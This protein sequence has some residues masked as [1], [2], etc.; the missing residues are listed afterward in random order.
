MWQRL[1]QA[2][3]VWSSL[4][5]LAALALLVG[6]G[7][8]Q[9]ERLAWKE[10]LLARLAARVAAEPISLAAVERRWQADGDVEYLHALVRGRFHHDQERYLYAPQPA[11]LGW[12]VYTPLEVSPGRVLWV[13]RGW[14]DE[15]HKQPQQRAQG[16]LAGET[17]VRGLIRGPPVP[18]LFTPAND[19]AGNLWYWPDLGQMTISAFGTPA[20]AS[21]PFRLEA[22]GQPLPPGGLPRGGVTRLDLPNR[23]LEYALTWFALALA[24]IVVYFVFAR[25]RLRP[26][27][28][29]MTGPHPHGP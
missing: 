14:V 5:V 25:H 1:R 16:Q 4:A 10:A 29:T 27:G 19:A 22:D 26:G 18:G 17:E 7:F 3:L 21:L 13:N 8:W 23:H 9:L 28:A 2:G 15:A 24:L 12:H 11:G 20:P 6:L